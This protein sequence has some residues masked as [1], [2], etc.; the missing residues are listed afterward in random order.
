ML[1]FK[2]KSLCEIL[3]ELKFNATSKNKRD[4]SVI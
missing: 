1:Q 2:S 3:E 4:V